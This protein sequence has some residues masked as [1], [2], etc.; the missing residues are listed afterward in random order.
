MNG[1]KRERRVSLA[2][3]EGIRN[4]EKGSGHHD[5]SPGANEISV[6]PSVQLECVQC[7]LVDQAGLGEVVIGLEFA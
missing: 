2:R 4:M 7:R 3:L 5:R 1:G 6:F